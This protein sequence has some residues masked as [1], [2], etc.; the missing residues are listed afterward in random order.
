MCI[1]VILFMRCYNPQRNGDWPQNVLI[2]QVMCQSCVGKLNP[3]I[4]YSGIPDLVLSNMIPVIFQ[5]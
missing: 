3:Q 1:H 4:H 5:I 2:P